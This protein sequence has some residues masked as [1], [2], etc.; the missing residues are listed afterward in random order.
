MKDEYSS[1]VALEGLDEGVVRAVVCGLDRDG[2]IGGELCG[3]FGASY[4]GDVESFGG[5]ELLESWCA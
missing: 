4:E 3:R 2:R 5:E 1:L